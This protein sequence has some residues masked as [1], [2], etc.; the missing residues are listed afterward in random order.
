MAGYLTKAQILAVDDI[1]FEDVDVPEWDGKVRVKALTGSERDALEQSMIEGRGKHREMNLANFRA[2]LASHS[3]VDENGKRVF[4]DL[5]VYD[6]GRKS[7]AAL[8]RVFNVASRLSGFTDDDI[9]ELVKNSESDPSG[10]SG[11]N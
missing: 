10:D 8:A 6:L 5:D 2:K 11:T 4:N 7:G 9:D 1:Q 3:I